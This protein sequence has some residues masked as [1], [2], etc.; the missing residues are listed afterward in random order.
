L[1]WRWSAR[2]GPHES[3]LDCLVVVLAVVCSFLQGQWDYMEEAERQ[4]ALQR[5]ENPVCIVSTALSFGVGVAP[6]G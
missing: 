2:V 4:D 6:S 3:S 1:G 5:C